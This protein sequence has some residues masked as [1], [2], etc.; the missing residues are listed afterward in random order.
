M[1]YISIELQ[2]QWIRE[3]LAEIKAMLN[4][5]NLALLK[6]RCP[7]CGEESCFYY[8]KCQNPC[9]D[10]IFAKSL[11]GSACGK[12]APKYNMRIDFPL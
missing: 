3:D 8:S 4:P 7:D 11:G 12:H 5:S 6:P 9:A 1:I 10:C 2:L